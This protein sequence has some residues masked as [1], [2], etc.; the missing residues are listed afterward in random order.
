MEHR[1]NNTF[2]EIWGALMEAQR[3]VIPLHRSPDPDSYC[4]A[5]AA[6]LILTENGKDVTIV[7]VDKLPD[8][9]SI[10]NLFPVVV[11]DPADMD[12]S[13]F[14]LFLAQDIASEDR[15]SKNDQFEIPANLV[16]VNIDHHTTNTYFG[17]FNY[18]DEGA[19]ST[20]EI[21][22]LMYI[23]VG[24]SIS[25]EIAHVLFMGLASDSGWFTFNPRPQVYDVAKYLVEAGA[26]TR[27]IKT[28][29]DSNTLI[30]VVLTGVSHSRATYDKKNKYVYSYLSH[31]DY[32]EHS[33]TADQIYS[34]VQEYKY[35][36][37]VEIDFSWVAQ[38]K[39]SGT[40][41]LSLRAKEAH[42]YDVSKIAVAL[43][44]GGHT[45]AA[46]CS[47]K[48]SSIDEVKKILDN[49]LQNIN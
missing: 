37:D 15:Y 9:P 27:K 22:T 41:T 3:I 24:V 42:P 30:N 6:A 14:D 48:A 7:S 23:H 34:G 46:G 25:E 19:I 20:A 35:I 21:L 38:E 4:S 17:T 16:V 49:V 12:L 11:K 13:E 45:A 2:E 43:G 32:K 39:D 26:D 29:L 1:R 33:V 47:V 8:L 31:E 18:V 5:V 10:R 36:S 40:W 44:G 28:E